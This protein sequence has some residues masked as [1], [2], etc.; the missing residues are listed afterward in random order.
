MAFNV[1][2]RFRFSRVVG[3]RE[4]EREIESPD[5]SRLIFHRARYSFTSRGGKF[6]LAVAFLDIEVGGDINWNKNGGG[7]RR[8]IRRGES[9]PRQRRNRSLNRRR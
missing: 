7:F 3:E 6:R 9:S 1:S 8:V 5:T 2:F 4:R